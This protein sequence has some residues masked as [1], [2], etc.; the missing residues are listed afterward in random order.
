MSLF[1]CDKCGCVEILLCVVIILKEMDLHYVQ[2]VIQKLVNGITVFLRKNG[3]MR[4]LKM[5]KT[6]DEEIEEVNKFL[7]KLRLDS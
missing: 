4:R 5:D 6:T 1:K 7:I 3:Q 2:N